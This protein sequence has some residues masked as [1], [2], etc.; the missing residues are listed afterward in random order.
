[1]ISKTVDFFLKNVQQ[2][3]Y[4]KK[5]KKL[6]IKKSKRILKIVKAIPFI[7]S[8]A[9]SGGTANYGIDNHDDIDLFIITKPN[10]VFIAYF[11]IHLISKIFNARKIICANYLIDETNLTINNFEDVYTANQIISLIPL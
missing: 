10:S 3:Y 2:N 4:Q 5:E 8:I 6:D 11:L 7:S 9:F 1:M